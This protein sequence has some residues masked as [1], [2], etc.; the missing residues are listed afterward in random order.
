MDFLAV[1]RLVVVGELAAQFL[2]EDI[3]TLVRLDKEL[4]DEV[5]AF[6]LGGA[7]VDEVIVAFLANAEKGYRTPPVGH[8]FQRQVGVAVAVKCT[9]LYGQFVQV[10][11]ALLGQ[12]HKPLVVQPV[13]IDVAVV[14]DGIETVLHLVEEEV[15][16]LNQK[17]QRGKQLAVFLD[18]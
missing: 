18:V 8:H 6:A 5:L 14:A 9:A 11:I 16:N 2:D 12:Q 7:V 13:V 15:H 4:I 1:V 10:K 3:G 17:D